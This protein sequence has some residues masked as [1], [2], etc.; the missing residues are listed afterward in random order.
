MWLA[1][2]QSS[3]V[4][5]SIVV[6]YCCNMVLIVPCS[7]QVCLKGNLC[8]RVPSTTYILIVIGFVDKAQIFARYSHL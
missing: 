3:S 2:I 4:V 5:Y 1:R 8:S 7:W 6:V